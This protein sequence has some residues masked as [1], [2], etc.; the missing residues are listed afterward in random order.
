MRTQK[1]ISINGPGGF[2]EVLKIAFPLILSTS[3]FTLQLFFDRVL[4]MWYD[5]DAMSGALMGGLT[6]FVVFS[7]FLGTISYANTFVSQYDGANRPERIG[8]AVWQALYFCAVAGCVMFLFSFFA[9]TIT[10]I[11]DHAESIRINEIK[12][13]RI[14]AL[15][16]TPGFINAALSSFY[17]GRGKTTVVMWINI[18]RTAVNI[19]L[20]YVL[21]FGKFGFPELGIT[22]AAIATVSSGAMASAIYIGLFM[23]RKNQRKYRTAKYKFETELFKRLMKFGLPSGTQF[24]LDILGFTFFVA[25][26]GKINE[27]AMAATTMA[28]QINSLA[29]MPMIGI[30]IA[31]STLVGRALGKNNPALAQKST[32]SAGILTFG[33]MMS[34][35]ACYVL[36]PGVFMYAFKAR[37]DP[38]QFE[39]I[40]P[41]V[42]KLLVFIAFYCVFDTG[43]IIF[44]AALKGAGDTRFVMMVSVVLNW[45]VMVIPTWLAVN[46]LNGMNRLYV[47]W[48]WLA[49]YVCA[50]SIIFL[51]RFIGGKWKN[52][53]VIEKAPAVPETLPAMPTVET[54][55][56]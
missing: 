56:A 5:R 54:E 41:L 50:L 28:S 21:I 39:A 22:G 4:L 20:D 15:G 37:S 8:P 17:T 46:F 43:N 30:G 9:K 44:A 24:M 49:T 27:V 19:L 25:L 16:A 42:E 12:Y 23:S 10:G 51:F 38:T 53:R 7:F 31:T 32:W 48:G 6:N 47:A 36:L 55:G 1:L 34:I 52:M 14:L 35:A 18:L 26:I 3:A 29:F 13:F 45:L 2:S 40:R 11:M 33:Y